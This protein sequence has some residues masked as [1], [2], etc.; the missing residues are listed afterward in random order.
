MPTYEEE[1]EE[2]T[3]DSEVNDWCE[4][5]KPIRLF[6]CSGCGYISSHTDDSHSDHCQMCDWWEVN[7]VF[8]QKESEVIELKDKI[9]KYEQSLPEAAKFISKYDDMKKE[10]SRFQKEI[11]R[12]TDICKLNGNQKKENVEKMMNLQKE[13][14]ELKEVKK[15]DNQTIIKYRKEIEKLQKEIQEWDSNYK[16]IKKYSEDLE[17]YRNA[18]Q[19]KYELQSDRIFKLETS[20]RQKDHEWE[21]KIKKAIKECL[22]AEYPILIWKDKFLTVL[23]IK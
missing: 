13:N 3:S 5:N 19:E 8:V 17:R 12:L 2:F 4:E 7:A 15:E 1:I 14:E 23:N 20:L 9:L 11:Q 18:E 6:V 10:I 21:E 16:I 22:S